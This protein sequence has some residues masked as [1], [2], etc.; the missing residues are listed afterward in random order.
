MSINT[1]RPLRSS[2]W[3][4]DPYNPADC[5]VWVLQ[6]V[7]RGKV[8]RTTVLGQGAACPLD[9]VNRQF[10]TERA[11]QLWD[12]ADETQDRQRRRPTTLRAALSHR[13]TGVCENPRHNKRLNRF[14]LR[15]RHKVDTQWKLYCMVHNIEK[16]AHHGYAQ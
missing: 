13:G 12:R 6:G 1:E 11:N 2:R 3:G 16:L 9:K 7:R 15:G 14:T 10:R 4:A 5:P 8:V